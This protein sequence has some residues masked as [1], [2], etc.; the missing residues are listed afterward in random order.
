MERTNAMAALQINSVYKLVKNYHPQV[1]V[2]ECKC[3]KPA[4][5]HAEWWWGW[6]WWW[7]WWSFWGVKK[8]GQKDFC[9]LAGVIKLIINEQDIT[10]RTVLQK[11]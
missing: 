3:R 7:W 8:A 11:S 5:Q 10:V 2:E 4:M 6:W 9:N 1:Y